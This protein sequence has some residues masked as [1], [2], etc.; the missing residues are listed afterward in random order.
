MEAGCYNCFFSF[1]IQ[2]E[3]E[4]CEEGVKT[5]VYDT[6]STV[7]LLQKGH[8]CF[9]GLHVHTDVGLSHTIIHHSLLRDRIASEQLT[10]C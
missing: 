5:Y 8:C 10:T 3:K 2:H 7:S 4:F 9:Y 6:L 1:I